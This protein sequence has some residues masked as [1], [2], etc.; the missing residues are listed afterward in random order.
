LV[1]ISHFR[2]HRLIYSSISSHTQLSIITQATAA[3][4]TYNI[5]PKHTYVKWQV[6]HVGFSMQSGK[7]MVAEGTIHFDQAKPQDS[8]VNV[9]IHLA[10]VNSGV[11]ALDTHLKSADFFD[12]EKFPNATFVSDKITVTGKDSADIQGTLTLHGVAKPITLHTIFN[13][14]GEK[15][16]HK[17]A[18][19]FNA[20]TKL[21]RSD[22]GITKLLPGVGDE[23]TLTIGAEA[24]K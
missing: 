8:K 5:D 23:V 18:A 15:P 2:I 17:I 4:E 11:P 24:I 3:A 9:T 20:S 14:V 16:D 22:F 7:W 1:V 10:D 21:K 12:V 19:G 13:K 6:S